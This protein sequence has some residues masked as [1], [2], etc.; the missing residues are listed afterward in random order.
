MLDALEISPGRN[1]DGTFKFK[2]ALNKGEE[3]RDIIERKT[4][5]FNVENIS[6]YL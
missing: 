4:K 6:T 3:L 1:K 5:P 2:S